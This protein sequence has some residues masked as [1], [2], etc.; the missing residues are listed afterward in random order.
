[1]TTTSIR[2]VTISEVEFFTE[3]EPEEIITPKESF[4]D[5][6]TQERQIR[7]QLEQGNDYAWC[8]ITVTAIWEGIAGVASLGGVSASDEA[9]A[10]EVAAFYELKEEAVAHLNQEIQAYLEQAARIRGLLGSGG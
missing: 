10:L 1:M 4:D 3:I 2:D 9:G 7:E 6:G 5:D 8:Q